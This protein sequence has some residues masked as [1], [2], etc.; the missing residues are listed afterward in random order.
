M[1]KIMPELYKKRVEEWLKLSG[2]KKSPQNFVNYSFSFS[3]AL[4]FLLSIFI[5]GNI[6]FVWAIGTVSLFLLFHGLL[7]LAVDRRTAFVERVLPD[8][9]QLMAANSRAGYI[10]SQSLLLSARKEFGPLATAIKNVGKDLMTGKSLENSLRKITKEIRSDILNRTADMIIE[11]VRSGG[12]F[13]SLLEE[14]ADDI[15][16]MQIIKRE[17]KANIVMYIIFIFFAGCIGAPLLYALSG[18][19]ISTLTKLG[20]TAKIP[21]TVT[22]K[23]PLMK[24]GRIEL[25]TEF[26]NQ[27]SIAAIIITTVFGGI[28]IGLISHG[29]E[30]AGIKYIPILVIL[31]LLVYYFAGIFIKEL[32]SA[33][34]PVA[35]Q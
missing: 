20:A 35:W 12:Q 26:L 15:R 21:E 33:F 29:R 11:G 4:G 34:L 19:L 25:S 14:N 3:I 13:S 6:L 5:G 27:F 22:S 1:Y 7:I 8:A 2:S 10:P 18:F 16:R 31:A 28:I 17:M 30:R 23:L 24:F 9:L 32:F